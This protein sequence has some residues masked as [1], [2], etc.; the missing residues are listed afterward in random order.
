M[1]IFIYGTLLDNKVL[2]KALRGHPIQEHHA[3]LT[4]YTEVFKGNY[5]NLAVK[6]G[7]SVEGKTFQVTGHDVELLD[8]W[9]EKY[10]RRMVM[11][12]DGKA[13]QAYVLKKE[14]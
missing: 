2:A 3:K 4:G 8:T 13:A 14:E 7:A 10:H 1:R 6:P 12:D 9:E 5:P 11:L